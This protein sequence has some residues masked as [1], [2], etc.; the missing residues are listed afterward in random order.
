[1]TNE[2]R[3]ALAEKLRN[4]ATVVQ[5]AYRG[6]LARLELGRRQVRH[7]QRRQ[8]A[9]LCIQ[10]N[11]RGSQTRA[12]KLIATK[13]AKRDNLAAH[14]IQ[15]LYRH[16]AYIQR[17]QREKEERER[18]AATMIQSL[19]RGRNGRTRHDRI[20]AE[21]NAEQAALTMSQ[22]DLVAAVTSSRLAA[23]SAVY[24]RAVEGVVRN[25]ECPEYMTKRIIFCK[26]VFEPDVMD[27]PPP[28]THT[29]YF[30]PSRY[31]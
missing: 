19:F 16:R 31:I 17:R 18:N 25:K 27:P 13:R 14:R 9:A 6:R 4:A 7:E 20:R 30:K 26:Y 28:H 11:Y 24:A 29:E 2:L 8:A 3:A 1:M 23:D 22:A 15:S 12:K 21:H 10:S 5:T